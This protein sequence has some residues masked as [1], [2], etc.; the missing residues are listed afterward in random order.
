MAQAQYRRRYHREPR[1]EDEAIEIADVVAE[2]AHRLTEEQETREPESQA[3][4][5]R[6]LLRATL[7][8]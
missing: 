5:L 3:G 2:A 8:A 4:V 1:Q 6:Q 7:R